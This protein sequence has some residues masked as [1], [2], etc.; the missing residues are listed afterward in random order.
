[1]YLLVAI[2]WTLVMCIAFFM[3]ASGIPSVGIPH[4]DKVVHFSLFTGFGLVWL[5]AVKGR[6][7]T[8]FVF[9]VGLV[10]AILSETLQG[11]LPTN[12]TPSSLDVVANV[13]GLVTA[14]VIYTLFRR[15]GRS[16]HDTRR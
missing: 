8:A 1:V 3:P 12:R 11:I 7:R 9:V 15:A 16:S 13:L 5:N 6:R 4:I 10:F 14:L 2:L